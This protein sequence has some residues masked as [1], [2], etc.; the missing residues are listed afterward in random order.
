MLAIGSQMRGF[1][2]SIGFKLLD[3]TFKKTVYYLSCG[4]AFLYGINIY[5][6]K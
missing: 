2:A 3:E 5:L 1:D 6:I 4:R